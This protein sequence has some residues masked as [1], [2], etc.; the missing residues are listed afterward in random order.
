MLLPDGLVAAPS[1]TGLGFEAAQEP[2]LVQR[3]L[4][5]LEEPAD[6]VDQF[7]VAAEV[8]RPLAPG[9]AEGQ[10]VVRP[11]APALVLAPASDEGPLPR[12]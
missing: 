4:E 2:G 8:E 10:A 5:L 11:E 3:P 1:G 6:P 7:H 9:L 12:E